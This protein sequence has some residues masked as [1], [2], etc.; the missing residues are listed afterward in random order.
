MKH[1]PI[2][3]KPPAPHAKDPLCVE[4]ILE[5]HHGIV[6]EADKGT[7]ALETWSHLELETFI[8]HVIEENVR[9]DTEDYPALRG[10]SVRV[11]HETIFQAACLQPLINHPSDDPILDSP[12]KKV[13]K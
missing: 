10:A 6:G 9:Q 1:Q 13:S 7:S 2:P 3:C 11:A 5:R 4:H 12:V 8:Q